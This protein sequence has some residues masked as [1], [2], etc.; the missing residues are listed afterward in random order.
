MKREIKFRAWNTEMNNMVFPSLEFGREIWPCTYRRI[1]K[2]ETNENGCKVEVVLEMVSVDNILQSPEFDVME[3]TGLLDKNGKEI[4]EGDILEYKN[5]FG[6]H[7]KHN[8]FYV[9]GGF[10]IN[11]H[12]SDF[13]KETAFYEA[14]ADYQTSQYI[15]QCEVIGNIYELLNNQK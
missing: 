7:N 12:Q 1:R 4:Y 9:D 11:T 10:A 2:S 6:K 13:L 15:E 5:D 3:F 8:V 14:C